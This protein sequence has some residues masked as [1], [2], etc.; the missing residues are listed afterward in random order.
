MKYSILENINSPKDLKGLS[1]NEISLLAEEIRS[2]LI[3][4]VERQGGHLASNLG[5]VELTLAIHSVFDSPKDHIIFDVGHQSYVHKLITGRREAFSELRVPGGL[6]GFTKRDES[7]HDPFGAGH[8]STSLSAALGF[9]ESD[10][11]KGINAH[12]VCVIGDGAYTGGMI[13]EA[14]NNCR[15]ELPLVIVL[16]ENGMSISPNKGSFASYISRVRVSR[17]YIRLKRGANNLLAL[18]PLIGI[19]LRKFFAFT[20]DRIKNILYS[21]N[22]FEELGLYYIGPIDGN[23]YT[24]LEQALTRAKELSKTV[25]VHIKTQKGK[26]YT[27]AEASPVSYHSVSGRGKGETYG[28]VF[29]RELISIAMEDERIVGITAAMGTGTG[30]DQFAKELPKRYFDV[31]IAEPHA[32]TFAAGLAASGMIPFV[33][34]YSTFL[35]RAYDSVLHDVALQRLPVKIMID[36]AGLALGDG[37]TH[38]GIFDVSFLSAIPGITLIAP[39]SYNS[40]KDAIRIAARADYPVA[41]RYPNAEE[42]TELLTHFSPIEKDGILAPLAD[43]DIS[44]PPRYIF[45]TYGKIS[46]KVMQAKRI[47]EQQGVL[48]GIIILQMLKPYDNAANK[49]FGIVSEAEKTV[50]V[51]EGIKSGGA[52]QNL[53]TELVSRGLDL[54]RVKVEISAIDDNFASPDKVC[55]LYDYVGLSPEKLAGRMIKNDT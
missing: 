10:N 18:I 17:K 9:A 40:L 5:V 33:T 43:F 42:N 21:T 37:A 27:P 19:P 49:I 45:V 31:G 53:M 13:H 44:V 12:T 39:I 1:K 23:D 54:S 34:V 41:I 25:V 14:L 22:Y 36:R 15:P 50:L 47:L 52:M 48:S 32:L 38:H 35:Q 4:T 7:A 8:S 16:N 46:E 51:E 28:T 20:R 6:S 24:K 11:M 30:L 26:G 2:F 29:A 55:D 3:E